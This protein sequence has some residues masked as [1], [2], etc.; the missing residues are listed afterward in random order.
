MLYGTL[1]YSVVNNDTSPIHAEC[2]HAEVITVSTF[3]SHSLLFPQDSLSLSLKSR[4]EMR[5]IETFFAERK[6]PNLINA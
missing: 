6:V 5:H 3:L 1:C 4:R 2:F